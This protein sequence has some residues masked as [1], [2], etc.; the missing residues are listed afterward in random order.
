MSLVSWAA[1]KTTPAAGR[2]SAPPAHPAHVTNGK[3]AFRLHIVDTNFPVYTNPQ[4]WPVGDYGAS[5]LADFDCDGDLDFTM[6]RPASLG[7]SVVYWCEYQRPD[8]WITH[9]AGHDT[10]TSVGGE[11]LD[12]DGDGWTDL[13]HGG[14][15]YRNTGSPAWRNS[16]GGF[17]IRRG[18][19]C[20]MSS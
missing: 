4:G 8:R 9:I 20:T 16:S 15:W 19:A 18:A 6:A 12:V 14:A 10:V 2:L 3:W 11:V 17:S 13:V 1:M 7:P 5:G